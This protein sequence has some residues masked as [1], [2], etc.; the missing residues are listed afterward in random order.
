MKVNIKTPKMNIGLGVQRASSGGLM[1]VYKGPDEPTDPN[2]LIWIDTSE[3][4][5]IENQ[6]ITAD[7]M[8]FI[9]ADNENFIVKE[10]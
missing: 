8:E 5:I 2:I 6:L 9:T 4:P 1:Q 10:S 7:N 3:E